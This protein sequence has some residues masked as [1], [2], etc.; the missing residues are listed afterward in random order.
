MAIGIGL[1]IVILALAAVLLFRAGSGL[2][3]GVFLLVAFALFCTTP[4]G[5]GVPDTVGGWFHGADTHSS[6]VV[7]HGGDR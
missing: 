7:Q 6:S 1:V 4:L 5:S 2:F 3:G